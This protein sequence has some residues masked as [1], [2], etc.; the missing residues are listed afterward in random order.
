MLIKNDDMFTV[1]QKNQ[2]RI[3]ALLGFITL[4]A[5]LIIVTIQQRSYDAVL[6]NRA[7]LLFTTMT[8]VLLGHTLSNH[9]HDAH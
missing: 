7:F 5:I 9:K 6:N 4:G 3:M 8:S 2:A 1:I